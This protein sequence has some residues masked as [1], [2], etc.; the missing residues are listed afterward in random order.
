[1]NC[2]CTMNCLLVFRYLDMA[3]TGKDI[4]KQDGNKVIGYIA[5]NSAG[6]DLAWNF[7]RNNF[8]TLLEMYVHNYICVR[9]SCNINLQS[10]IAYN[11][12]VP[13]WL[14]T[15]QNCQRT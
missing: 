2:S 6:R 10:N 11:L 15:Y 13:D 1:M 5:Q 7:V 3:I 14:K 9:L 4:R 12:H 8:K